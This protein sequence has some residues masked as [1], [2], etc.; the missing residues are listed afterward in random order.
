MTHS[1][2]IDPEEP[3][4]MYFCT[5]SWD[6][7]TDKLQ[8]PGFDQYGVYRSR[9]EGYTWEIINDGL[10]AEANVTQLYLDP[11]NPAIIYAAVMK[12]MD[13]KTN[14]GLYRSRNRGDAWERMSIPAQIESVNSVDLCTHTGKIYISCGLSDGSIESGGVWESEDQG[15]TWHKIFHMPFVYQVSVAKY[16]PLR[17]A[18]AVAENTSVQYLNPGAYLSFDGGK[19]W[20]KSNRGLGQPYWIVDLKW[21]LTNPDVI[22]CG[23][24][25][26]GWY[27]GTAPQK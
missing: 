2:I 26:S 1:L 5:P 15:H 12:S 22:W 18:V 20:N 23:L 17:I 7:H 24:L 4:Y 9:D 25:G 19:S 11:K 27:K 16:D 3:Q 8:N 13:M 10:P 21:D 6:K 14:G